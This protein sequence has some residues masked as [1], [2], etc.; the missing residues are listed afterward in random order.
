MIS[1]LRISVT[2]ELALGFSWIY[3]KEVIIEEISALK[4]VNNS[5]P[6][7]VIILIALLKKLLSS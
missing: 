3:F 7:E 2:V 4:L 5:F 1:F 6:W